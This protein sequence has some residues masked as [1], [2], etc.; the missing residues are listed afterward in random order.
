LMFPR[1]VLLAPSRGG[2]SI[3]RK[4]SLSEVVAARI[5]G[6]PANRSTLVGDVR[7]RSHRRV[8]TPKGIEKKGSVEA[9]AVAALRLGDVRKALQVLSSAPFAPRSG[10]TLT[11]L[12]DLHPPSVLPLPPPTEV[13]FPGFPRSLVLTALSSFGAGSGAGL[14]GYRPFL[15]Q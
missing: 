3:S 6:W 11:A 12:R 14:F 10:E 2:R 8:E 7:A 1:C 13:S 4:T 5:Q 9:A 15:L